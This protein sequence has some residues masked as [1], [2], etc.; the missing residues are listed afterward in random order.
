M[1]I[2]F[3]EKKEKFKNPIYKKKMRGNFLKVFHFVRFKRMVKN[4]ISPTKNI[5]AQKIKLNFKLTEL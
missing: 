2:D 5:H 1:S 3:D 4:R